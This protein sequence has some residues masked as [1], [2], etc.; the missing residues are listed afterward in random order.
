MRA[1]LLTFIS[2]R[3][4]SYPRNGHRFLRNDLSSIRAVRGT[5]QW[6]KSIRRNIFEKIEKNNNEHK[7]HIN[8]RVKD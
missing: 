6:P 4:F 2:Y 8:D 5:E 3:L 7:L 1:D